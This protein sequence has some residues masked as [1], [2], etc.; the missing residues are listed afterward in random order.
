MQPSKWNLAEYL[1][2][3]CCGSDWKH[4]GRTLMCVI[5]KGCPL[6]ICERCRQ[7]A[8]ESAYDVIAG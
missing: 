5:I 1:R 4:G 7:N 2:C 3:Q 8:A 6:T